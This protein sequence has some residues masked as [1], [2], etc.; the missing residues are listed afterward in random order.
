M[1]L[2]AKYCF[3]SLL[4]LLAYGSSRNVF[5]AS[6]MMQVRKVEVSSNEEKFLYRIH[7]N[8]IITISFSSMTLLLFTIMVALRQLLRL[9]FLLVSGFNETACPVDTAIEV[10]K[11]QPFGVNVLPK[12]GPHSV[13]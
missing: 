9:D 3:V 11:A 10:N 5:I 4:S 2:S 1:N 6:Q 12:A 7:L 8:L 13:R